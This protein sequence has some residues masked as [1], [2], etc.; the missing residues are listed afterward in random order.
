[1][2]L[3]GKPTDH[4]SSTPRSDQAPLDL[5]RRLPRAELG[6]TAVLGAGGLLIKPEL[7]F[8]TWAVGLLLGL[9]QIRTDVKTEKGFE[10]V[11]RLAEIVDISSN[12]DIEQLKLLVDAYSRIPEPEFQTVKDNVVTLARDELLRL[13]RDKS[14]GELSTG[15][16]YRWLLPM[17]G[18]APSGSTI[19]ALSLMLQCEWDE[20]Q[21]EESFIEANIQ[22]AR[23][24]VIISRIFVMPR[25]L[26]REA[27][28]NPA[29][30][31]HLKE[32]EPANLRGYFVDLDWL[33]QHDEPLASKLGDGFIAFDQQ[34]VALIDLHSV[35]GSI[36]GL[37]T[38]LPA[39]LAKIRIVHEELAI[40][41]RELSH[42]LLTADERQVLAH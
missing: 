12:T 30:R 26:L 1:M 32:V 4:P 17:I 22:A 37:V 21:A 25:T 10:R 7:G 33:Q 3:P 40:H 34:E 9:N 11:N 15:T 28:E 38:K 8:I 20:S 14:S 5:A 41:A 31:S 24:G 18:D 35:S 19:K 39:E 6:A 2:R 29:V 16:Y 42:D 23:R 27:C 36:R 13:A